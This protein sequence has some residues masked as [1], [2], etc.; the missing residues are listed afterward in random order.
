MVMSNVLASE[1]VR[2]RNNL[3]VLEE[4][5]EVRRWTRKYRCAPGLERTE[6]SVEAR[7]KDRLM[8]RKALARQAEAKA[9]RASGVIISE[10]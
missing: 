8:R 2:G 10:E 4:L 1:R 7:E 3:G 6:A 5:E 9:R